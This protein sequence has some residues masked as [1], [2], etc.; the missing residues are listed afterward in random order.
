MPRLTDFLRGYAPFE[1]FLERA[2]APVGAPA[3]ARL[4][5]PS[6]VHPFLT[7]AIAGRRPWSEDALVVVAANQEAALE[8]EHELALYRPDRPVVY[9]PPRGVWYGSEGEVQPRVAGR[10]ARAVAALAAAPRTGHEQAPPVVVVE[11]TTLMEGVIRPPGP[12][13]LVSSGARV[14]FE[15]LIR[16]LVALGYTRRDQVEDAG[17][18]SVRGG[19]I[20]VFP[21]TERSP[22]R[23]EFWGDEVESL[24]SFSVYSQRSLGPV[25]GVRLHAAAEEAGAS[26]VN[27][28]S[29]L[30]EGTRV[31]RLDP[32]R[33]RARVETFEAD[34]LDVLEGGYRGDE[35]E[36]W[37]AV[38]ERLARLPVIVL[39][40]LGMAGLGEPEATFRATSGELPVTNLPEAEEAIRR[41]ASDGYRVV[42]AF[43][44]RAEAERAGYVLRRTSGTLVHGGEVEPG[45]GVSFLPIALRRH[46]LIPEIKLAVLTDAQVF[47]RRHKAASTRRP[48]PG[49][50]LSSF[51][52]LRKGDYVVHED[53][54]V[55]RFEG[56]ST[57]T[58]AGVTRDYLDL[59]YR[60]TD[61]LYVPH[62][63]IGKV[64][65]YVG[66]GGRRRAS[67]NWAGR[68]G[69]TSRAAS[70]AQPVRWLGSCCISTPCAWPQRAIA[71]PR[72]ASGRSASRRPF[73]TTRPRTN[74]G[75]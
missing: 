57:K 65:R 61:M 9:L 8:L 73:P 38:E 54:G 28:L 58:V 23:I 71:S 41:L 56:I 47:P 33:A 20:D 29:L 48:T 60:D 32:A 51:R 63:Q 5:A 19:I 39:D 6:F 7:A 44:Q 46:F 45:P 53:H 14:D 68:P 21:A 49:V 4:A 10:R 13:L 55:G 22:V 62:D 43:E 64:M 37:P 70:G 17:D 2:T 27:L 30:P 59:A 18:F 74:S 69:S 66:A 40:S 24:R 50:T 75:P 31:V 11:A 16:G 34:L 35:Y 3:E 25:E 52:D 26:P 72:T 15:D 42:I 1:E 67:R 12:P 36:G